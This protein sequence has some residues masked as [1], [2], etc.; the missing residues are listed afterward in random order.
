MLHEPREEFGKVP[1][2]LTRID[3]GGDAANNANTMISAIAGGAIGV[4]GSKAAQNAG[5]VQKVAIR[6]SRVGGGLELLIDPGDQIAA[7]HIANEQKE[8][9]GHL[10]EMAVAERQGWQ[11][12]G[13]NMLGRPQLSASF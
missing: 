4:L 7:G 6:R 10:I 5:S 3:L 13:G 11:W 9:I 12:A 8:A 2:E 1:V